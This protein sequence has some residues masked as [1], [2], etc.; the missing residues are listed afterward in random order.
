MEPDGS[1]AYS[2]EPSATSYPEPD[3]SNLYHPI[4]FL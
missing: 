1:L 2:Q 3:K 4:L